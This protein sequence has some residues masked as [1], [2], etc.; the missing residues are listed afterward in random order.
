MQ[1][2]YYIRL[3][4]FG[5]MVSFKECVTMQVLGGEEGYFQKGF[6]YGSET[7]DMNYEGLKE[8]F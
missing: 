5:Q 2:K 6:S 7:S 1:K 3:G 8:M 4:S